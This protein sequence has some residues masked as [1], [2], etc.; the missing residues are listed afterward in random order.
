MKTLVLLLLSFSTTTA[1]AAYGLGLGQA[2][3]YPAD[4]RA[5]GYVYSGRQGWVLKTEADAIKLDTGGFAFE[6]Q[7]SLTEKG[8]YAVAYGL[9]CKKDC[10]ELHATDP[11]RTIP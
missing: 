1:F 3:K 5:Y 8:Q 2:P 4:F 6:V 11:R 10:H 9:S 7:L